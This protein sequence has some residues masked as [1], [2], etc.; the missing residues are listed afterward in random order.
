MPEKLEE[1]KRTILY[2]IKFTK[3]GPVKYTGHLDVMRFFQRVIRRAALPVAFSGGYSPH[4]VMSFAYPLS[5]GFTSTG[6][7]FD[8][9][10]TEEVPEDEILRRMNEESNCF[11]RILAVKR[12]PQGTRNCMSSVFASEYEVT[13]RDHVKL[14]SGW[15]RTYLSFCERE[16]IPVRKPK[17]K[18]GG[19]L[20]IDL[21]EFLYDYGIPEG[22]ERTIRFVINSGSSDN[23]KPEF[24][25]HCFLEDA[26]IEEGEF[27][28]R[29]H[30]TEIYE[31]TGKD[32][33][34]CLKGLL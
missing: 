12:M 8:V 5:L 33:E 10:F 4:P 24:F 7:Y 16:H 2:R 25:T 30:R 29:V 9:A 27:P 23:V 1:E 21:K 13:F 31:N 15:E 22:R 28:F 26:G 34:I 14:P 20:E 3:E 18:G 32:G 19:F 6:E 17:K 11:F